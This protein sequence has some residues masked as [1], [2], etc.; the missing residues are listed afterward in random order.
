MSIMV[1]RG[2]KLRPVLLNFLISALYILGFP[3][4]MKPLLHQP[5]NAA[6]CGMVHRSGAGSVF[7]CSWTFLIAWST[8]GEKRSL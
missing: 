7:P 6:Y 1:A 5:L 8:W 4:H 2:N 3:S